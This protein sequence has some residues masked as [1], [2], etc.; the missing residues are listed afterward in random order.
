MLGRRDSEIAA[1]M[2]DKEFV[3]HKRLQV[4]EVP[5]LLKSFE[6][7]FVLLALSFIQQ[8]SFLSLSEVLSGREY[9]SLIYKGTVIKKEE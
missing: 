8:S 1:I 4:F 9:L 6:S 2:K 7:S 3:S 5:V